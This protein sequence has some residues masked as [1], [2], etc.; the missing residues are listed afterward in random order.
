MQGR[1]RQRGRAQKTLALF[2]HVHALLERDNPQS[3]RQV[4]YQ[5]LDES[6]DDL[7]RVPKD[8]AG[9]RR[10]Q[11]ALLAM[12]RERMIPFRWIQD[13]SRT[14]YVSH[15]Y[16]DA[17]DFLAS[18]KGLYRQDLWQQSQYRVE[19]WVESR[20]IA[21]T[22]IGLCRALGVT[23][24]PTGGQA[25]DS[26]IYS[27]A[28]AANGDHDKI[29]SVLYVGDYDDAGMSIGEVCKRKLQEHVNLHMSFERVAILDW[30]REVF[31]L[32][33]KPARGRR[34]RIDRTIE[35]ESMPAGT[36]RDLIRAAIERHLPKDALRVAQVA[37]QHEREYL[38]ILQSDAEVREA[39]KEEVAAR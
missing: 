23:L 12:R 20:G 32:P 5:C 35:A 25:S 15:A 21:G 9:Y 4:F 30:Q 28:E 27:A 17:A 10:V 16:T 13:Y 33:T 8:D 26:F 3:V 11:R 37:E 22:L 39:R 34:A 2:D 6:V 29:L 7:A 1:Q 18:I 24:Y 19:V 36:L 14:A 38:D 31:N